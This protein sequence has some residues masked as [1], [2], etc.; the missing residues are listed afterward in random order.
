MKF[1]IRFSNEHYDK[2]V[3]EAFNKEI[4]RLK[5]NWMFSDPAQDNLI[6]CTGRNFTT[7]A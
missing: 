1:H 3:T 4:S 7:I 6:F 2:I 5:C